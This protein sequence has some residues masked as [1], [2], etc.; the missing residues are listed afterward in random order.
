[1]AS[2]F[3]DI[4]PGEEYSGPLM[5]EEASKAA[6]AAR[7]PSSHR[8]GDDSRNETTA[9]ASTSTLNPFAADAVKALHFA[10]LV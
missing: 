8:K 5:S 9:A 4:E 10:I 6:R 1:V 2:V 3:G 7:A